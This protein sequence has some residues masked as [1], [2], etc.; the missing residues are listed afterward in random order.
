MKRTKED[1]IKNVLDYYFNGDDV[2]P[3]LSENYSIEKYEKRAIDGTVNYAYMIHLQVSDDVVFLKED[4]KFRLY[5]P[6]TIKVFDI[7]NEIKNQLRQQ[8]PDINDLSSLMELLDLKYIFEWYLIPRELFISEFLKVLEEFSK[9]KYQCIFYIGDF[10]KLITRKMSKIL[11]HKYE[12]FIPSDENECDTQE[13][14][15]LDFRDNIELILHEL[16]SLYWLSLSSPKEI[17]RS[18][19]VM[20]TVD[21]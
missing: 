9:V 18:D 6:E 19:V 11:D 3:I 13:E 8:L 16:Y 5:I 10:D 2:I 17:G 4:I 15:I 12:Y 14:V 21:E 7:E 20:G 1:E